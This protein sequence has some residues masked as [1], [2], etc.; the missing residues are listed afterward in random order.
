[1]ISLPKYLVFDTSGLLSPIL[2]LSYDDQ[3]RKN[4]WDGKNE[5]FVKDK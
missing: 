2:L 1:M 3:F 5:R 4:V